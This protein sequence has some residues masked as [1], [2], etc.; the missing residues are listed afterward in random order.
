MAK[1]KISPIHKFNGGVGATLCN[2]CSKIITEG[3]CDE[4]YCEEHGGSPTYNYKLV[5]E[6]DQL[7]KHGKYA[8]WIEWNKDGTFKERH[9]TP[10]VGTSLVI[11]GR[12]MNYTWLT[13]TVTGVVEEREGYLKFKTKN[14]VYELYTNNKKV[15]DSKQ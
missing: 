2:T 15:A 4:I 6:H 12:F 3:F 1:K 5:R 10:L 11:D 13:T 8:D 9:D 7:T 14:S